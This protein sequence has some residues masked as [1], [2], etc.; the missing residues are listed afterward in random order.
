MIAPPQAPAGLRRPAARLRFVSQA[1][2]RL[3]T[4][5]IVHRQHVR[6]RSTQCRAR[7]LVVLHRTLAPQKFHHHLLGVRLRERRH[8]RRER[9]GRWRRWPRDCGGH[10]RR[11]LLLHSA[12]HPRR[13][14]RSAG[15]GRGEGVRDGRRTGERVLRLGRTLGRGTLRGRGW[16]EAA[17]RPLWRV[18]GRRS[19]GER[20]T[21]SASRRVHWVRPHLGAG[22]SRE[23]VRLWRWRSARRRWRRRWR[24]RA[25]RKG[26]VCLHDGPVIEEPSSR[27]QRATT[28]PRRPGTARRGRRRGAWRCSRPQRLARR[29]RGAPPF[30]RA[31]WL[32]PCHTRGPALTPVSS[33]H[34]SCSFGAQQ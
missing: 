31:C 8:L 33:T 32:T 27:P 15:L 29:R 3:P 21:A 25:R 1:A 5:C 22:R 30:L 4:G 11:L 24:S 23:Q 26:R 16:G 9:G 34:R 13:H 2:S 19:W 10:G 17:R 18:A 28:E 20:R 6:P 7:Q 12:V 14:G